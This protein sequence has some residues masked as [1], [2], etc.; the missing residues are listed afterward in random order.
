MAQ[1]KSYTCSKCGG[2]LVVDDDQKIFECPFCGASFGI[3]DFHHDEILAQAQTSLRLLEL[4]S[5]EKNFELILERDPHNFDALR[6]LVYCAGKIST[7][8]HLQK[9]ERLEN[10]DLDKV[11]QVVTRAENDARP[12]DKLFFTKFHEMAD[13]AKAHRDVAAE[14]EKLDQAHRRETNRLMDI[15]EQK[16]SES[17]PLK[18][19]VDDLAQAIDSRPAFDETGE[20]PGESAAIVIIGI[21]LLIPAGL[22][23]YYMKWIGLLIYV[24]VIAL[25]L[26]VRAYFLHIYDKQKEPYRQEI[27]KLQ[28]EVRDVKTRAMELE[29]KYDE[30]LSEL[31]KIE[32]SR[33]K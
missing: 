16:Q 30:A 3:D 7:T 27:S 11:I 15:D 2:A 22:A 4:S 23:F 1:F 29:K 21:L 31:E 24:A 19:A 13:L 14:V 8:P 12:E 20:A 5:A 6:G 32:R 33:Q 25:I 9:I 10:S 18:N 26:G 17:H 28:A